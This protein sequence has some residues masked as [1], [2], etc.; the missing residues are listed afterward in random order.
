MEVKSYDCRT[1]GEI[2]NFAGETRAICQICGTENELVK[3][4]ALNQE[5]VKE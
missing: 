5:A 3:Q 4:E 1:C 2:L